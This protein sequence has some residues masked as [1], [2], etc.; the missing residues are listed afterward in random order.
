MRR[1]LKKIVGIARLLILFFIS[2]SIILVVLYRFVPPPLTPL[3]VIRFFEQISDPKQHVK[4]RKDWES[5]EHISPNLPLA[6]MASE[7][8]LFLKH[9]GFDIEA[10]KK[11]Y[12]HNNKKRKKKVSTRGASTISQQVAKNVF[13]WPGRSWLRKA[14][15]A[16]FTFL[17]EVCWSKE[18]IMEVYL[19][20]IEMGNGVYGAEAASQYYFKKPA[21]KLSRDEAALIAAILPNPLKWSPV[22]PTPYIL[23]KKEWIKRNMSYL[24]NTKNSKENEK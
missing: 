10:I 1:A 11:A 14:F 19:N 23:K 8:Q 16:Y 24:A 22:K 6:V 12:Q 5:I 18:R 20:M 13:L 15:E 9:F 7:D 4:F 17:I 3:M 21:S 2:W